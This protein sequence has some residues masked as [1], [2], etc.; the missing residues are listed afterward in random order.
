MYKEK[1]LESQTGTSVC[2]LEKCLLQQSL[3]GKIQS[4]SLEKKKTVWKNVS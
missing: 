1:Q 4:M 2:I 3:R